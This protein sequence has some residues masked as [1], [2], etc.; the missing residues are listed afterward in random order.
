MRNFQLVANS[1]VAEQDAKNAMYTGLRWVINNDV[2]SRKHQVDS[3][4]VFV[5][6]TLIQEAP[7][8]V[9][10]WRVRLE[11]VDNGLVVAVAFMDGDDL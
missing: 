3:F 5:E 7:I 6:Q 1:G 4:N 2:Q 11:N 9:T 10:V 8:A